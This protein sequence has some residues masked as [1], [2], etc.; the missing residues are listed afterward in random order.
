MPSHTSYL[1]RAFSHHSE[2]LDELE[3]ICL[4]YFD[5]D[6]EGFV[7]TGLSGAIIGFA[8]ADRLQK[9]FVYARKDD[10]STHSFHYRE[11]EML[12]ASIDDGG[13]LIFVDDLID[14]GDT[15]L[16]VRRL[17]EGRFP[18]VGK[19]L[20]GERRDSRIIYDKNLY[21]E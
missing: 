6:F 14:S 16:R 4:N 5:S 21:I 20:Y 15:F 17:V 8:L 11:G 9:G 2:T 12:E 1:S 3:A 18:I 10:D 13:R 7:F 19:L